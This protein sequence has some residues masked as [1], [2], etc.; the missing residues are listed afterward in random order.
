MDYPK[1]A[2]CMTEHLKTHNIVDR[3]YKR[4]LLTNQTALKEELRNYESDAFYDCCADFKEQTKSLSF[5]DIFPFSVV[6][7][8]ASFLTLFLC[9]V[10]WWKN[11]SK[12]KIQEK[13]LLV[14]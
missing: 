6:I 1:D 8:T 3:F 11:C 4:E 13:G 5:N 10:I 2:P 9:L 12:P 14:A 7:V